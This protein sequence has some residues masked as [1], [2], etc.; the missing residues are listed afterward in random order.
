MT[1][2]LTVVQDQILALLRSSLAQ[3]VHEVALPDAD[4]LI[5]DQNGKFTPY[6]AIQFGDIQQQGA[7]NMANA[8]N[9][10]YVMPIYCGSAGPDANIAR[11]IA[12]KLNVVL[13]GYTSDYTGEMEKR[14]GGM[15]YPIPAQMGAI[16]A[17]VSPASFGI[18]VEVRDL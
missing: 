14:A 4:T 12:N 5:R 6:V 11:R 2:T 7:R 9:H 10:N 16:E 15:M 1:D 17:Y 8:I 13:L 3:P 18:P